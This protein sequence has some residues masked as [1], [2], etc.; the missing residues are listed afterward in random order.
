MRLVVKRGGLGVAA[1]RGEGGGFVVGLAGG[2]AV[3]E[4]AEEAVVEVALGGGVAF[5]VVASAV[6]VGAGA[7]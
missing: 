1:G 5:V 3:V 7:G 4:A 2:E 6:V